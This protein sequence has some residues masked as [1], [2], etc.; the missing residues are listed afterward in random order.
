MIE[1]HELC[2]RCYEAVGQ[3]HD[4]WFEF[5]CDACWEAILLGFAESYYPKCAA[6]HWS[7]V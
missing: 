6:T 2:E 4:G 1:D 7:S 3:K 5:V